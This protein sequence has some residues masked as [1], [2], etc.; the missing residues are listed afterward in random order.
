[1]QYDCGGKRDN[2]V[3]PGRVDW[4]A[5]HLEVF[6]LTWEEKGLSGKTMK[7]LHQEL[8]DDIYFQGQILCCLERKEYLSQSQ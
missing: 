6:E 4:V 3:D 7:Y 8:E 2:Q 1:M 5:T